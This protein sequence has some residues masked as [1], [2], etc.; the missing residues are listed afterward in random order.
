MT[1][2]SPPSP[3]SPGSGSVSEFP[4]CTVCQAP[5]SVRA[6][7]CAVCDAPAPPLRRNVPSGEIRSGEWVRFQKPPVELQDLYSDL[8]KALLPNI[9]VLG[10]A[11]EG[12]M[13]LVF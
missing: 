11:G 13:A 12:C 4:H 5:V 7:T 10:M 1:Q 6:T 3:R 8:V 9:R 2:T